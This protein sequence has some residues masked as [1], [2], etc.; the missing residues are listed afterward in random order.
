MASCSISGSIKS[1]Y[2][3]NAKPITAM[4]QMSHWTTVRRGAVDSDEFIEDPG[5]KWNE[6]SGECL[7][8]GHSYQ[9]GQIQS[10]PKNAMPRDATEETRALR[11]M[12]PADRRDRSFRPRHRPRESMAACASSKSETPAGR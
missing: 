8:A 3:S 12:G 4:R 11:Q 9:L 6:Q 7:A 5:E 1:T 2:V 10:T